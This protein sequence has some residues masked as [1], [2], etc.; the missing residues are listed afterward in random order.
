MDVDV[1]VPWQTRRQSRRRTRA[2]QPLYFPLFRVT[3]WTCEKRALGS[4]SVVTS[5]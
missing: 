2:L 3:Q 4:Q 1:G 5:V